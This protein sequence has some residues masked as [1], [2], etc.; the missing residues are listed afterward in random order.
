MTGATHHID[1][2]ADPRLAPEL[3]ELTAQI[4]RRDPLRH[5]RPAALLQAATDATGLHDFGDDWF[6]TPLDVLCRSLREEAGLSPLG[7]LSQRAQ[8]VQLLSSRL[9]VEDI[10]RRHPEIEGMPIERP[11]IIAGLPRS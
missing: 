3:V 8:L 7:V 9:L 2:L 5:L 4:G 11:I 10:H 1:D 6:R